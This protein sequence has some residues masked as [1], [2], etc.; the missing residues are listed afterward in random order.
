MI[1]SFFIFMTGVRSWNHR[2]SCLMSVCFL[3]GTTAV[4]IYEFLIF[5]HYHIGKRY[6]FI[7]DLSFIIFMMELSVYP[8]MS[9]YSK[10]KSATQ[11]MVPEASWSTTLNGRYMIK[12]LQFIDF[13]QKGEGKY[14]SF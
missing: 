13:H 4:N 6:F 7:N 12:R 9:L 2:G 5:A 8:L 14:G 1:Y 3:V 11:G 10:L